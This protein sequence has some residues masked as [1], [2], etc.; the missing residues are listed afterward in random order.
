M[1]L[2]VGDY[3]NTAI[4]PHVFG[5]FRDLLEATATHPA[6][7]YY[8]DN[9]RNTA[10][11]KASKRGAFRGLN[12]NYAREIMELHTLGVDAGY[13]Q[14]DVVTL[15]RIL[16]GWGISPSGNGEFYFDEKRHDYSDKVFLGVSIKG[17]GI[18]EVEQALD[19]LAKHPAT[20]NHIGYKL[21]QYFVADEPPQSLI[22]KLSESYI[23]TDGDIRSVL[24][25]LFN[26]SEFLDS[27][28]YEQKFKTPY[29]FV[30]STV[31]AT[32]VKNPNLKRIQGMLK[33]LNMMVYDC[34]TPD[35]Y[36]NTQQAWLNPDGML[37]RLSF[38]TAIANGRLELDKNQNELIDAQQL[39]NTLGNNF[40]EHTQQVLQ[41][42]PPKIQGSIILGSPEMMY[43]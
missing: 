16:T 43:R 41:Q 25:T 19:I 32:G 1:F 6:M 42:T 20:A 14:E 33:Q 2:W 26:S 37:R 36:K 21:A 28:Y 4:R 38:T 12:E 29:Q 13:S 31:R 11:E 23:S 18:A 5:N 9:W 7:L 27:Q 40:S 34:P 39:I 30:I 15:A 10:P 17:S 35:G 24:T 22:T 3:E 8:L